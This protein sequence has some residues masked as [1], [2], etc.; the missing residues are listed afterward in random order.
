MDRH[1]EWQPGHRR[2]QPLMRAR[3][4]QSRV[5]IVRYL[6]WLNPLKSIS[7]GTR[8]S[9]FCFVFFNWLGAL[10][11]GI[12]TPMPEKYLTAYCAVALT[13]VSDLKCFSA[14]L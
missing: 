4:R 10:T 9:G 6:S 11:I 12:A 8:L 14:S 13:I 2:P 7:S 5:R 1:K 3:P